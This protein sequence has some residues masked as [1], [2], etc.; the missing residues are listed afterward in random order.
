MERVS[1]GTAVL[2]ARAVFQRS[3]NL[4]HSSALLR[5]AEGIGRPKANAN[6]YSSLRPDTPFSKSL[7]IQMGRDAIS[8]LAG[9]HFAAGNLDGGYPDHNRSLLF[10][11][12]A[13]RRVDDFSAGFRSGRCSQ[14]P[15]GTVQR[16]RSL[17]QAP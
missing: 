12:A 5:G 13:A 1:S 10:A 11:V 7:I 15:R 8:T 16:L 3:A 2:C 14:A 4:C 17:F 6:I 9:T